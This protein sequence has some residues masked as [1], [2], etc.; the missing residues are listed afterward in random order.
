MIRILSNSSPQTKAFLKFIR[1]DLEQHRVKLTFSRTKMVRFSHGMYTAGYFLEPS[2]RKWGK[3][4]VGTGN[5]KPINILMNIA[6]EYAHFLQWKRR[7]KEW[8]K[9]HGDLIEGS[10]YIALEKR[11]EKTAIE[12]L[13]EWGIPANYNAVRM[14]SNAYIAYL[15]ES[16]TA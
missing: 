16:E 2:A 4:R 7:E 9:G 13:K 1:N 15:R 6:H 14:R 10:K 8:S 11:T 5:R 3:I 12:L